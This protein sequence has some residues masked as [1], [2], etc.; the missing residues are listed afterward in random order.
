[1]LGNVNNATRFAIDTNTSIDSNLDGIPDNDTDNQELPSY[2]DGSI[3]VL[4][5]FSQSR[6][7]EQKI[8]L[9]L[10]Q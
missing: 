8:R 7:R 6:A 2:N 10:Y 9:S 5:D 3:F 4:K 1:M